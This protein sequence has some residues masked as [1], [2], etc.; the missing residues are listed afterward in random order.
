MSLVKYENF[1]AEYVLNGESIDIMSEKISEFLTSLGVERANVLGIRLSMEEALLRWYDHFSKKQEETKVGFFIGTTFFRPYISIELRGEEFDPLETTDPDSDVGD[2]VGTVMGNI[3]LSPRYSYQRGINALQLRLSRP[4]INPGLGLLLS[5]FIGLVAGVICKGVLSE[6]MMTI[7]TRKFFNPVQDVFFRLLEATAGP[8]IFLTV[9]TAICGIG[10]TTM[11]NKSGKKLIRNFLV[12]STFM[13]FLF[14]VLGVFAYNIDVY[15]SILTG[16]NFYGLF[17]FL[18]GFVPEDIFSPFVNTDSP[19]LILLAIVIGNAMLVLGS[20]SDRLVKIANQANSLGLLVAEW[21]SRLIPYVVAVLLAFRV[22][23]GTIVRFKLIWLPILL[24]HVFIVGLLAILMFITGRKLGVSARTIWEKIRKP[25]MIAL[26]NASVNAAFGETSISC[27]RKLGING[28][29][30][31]YGLPLGL[32]IYM[33]ASTVSLMVS[34]LYAVNCYNMTVSFLWLLM[35]MILVVALQAASPPVSG[36][37]TLAYAAIFTRLGI[38]TEA[39]IM[40]IV[41]DII[42]CFLSSAAN[43]AMLQMELLLEGNRLN[44]LDKE[45]L[46]AK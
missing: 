20:Q 22:M 35:A 25:F 21:I 9:L 37:D 13:T 5:I 31:D 17:D 24:F 43:Q 1:T 46:R 12:L 11:M 26:K 45:K 30:V 28:K 6:E 8:V 39:L 27:E 23:D 33:P 2:W 41:C 15:G 29:L 4:R 32:V 19:Q 18:L 44:M 42:F 36:V 38:P 10:S 16:T 7:I 40:A 34:T 3:G 14:T